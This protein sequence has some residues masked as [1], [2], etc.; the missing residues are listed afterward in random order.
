MSY[1]Q[2]PPIPKRRTMGIC[3]HGLGQGTAHPGG[4]RSDGPPVSARRSETGRMRRSFGLGTAWKQWLGAR[5]RRETGTERFGIVEG[6]GHRVTRW[7]PVF[8]LDGN[9]CSQGT[10]AGRMSPFSVI[11]SVWRIAQGLG[12]ETGRGWVR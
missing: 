11:C 3:R 8:Q 2:T 10:A 7:W 9:P 12:R 1:L 6:R 5:E 4:H